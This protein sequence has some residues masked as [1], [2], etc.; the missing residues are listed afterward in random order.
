M[1]MKRCPVCGEKYSDT[2]R[3][4]PFCEEE[5]ALRDGE[6]IR[7]SPRRG[8]RAPHG[9][10]YSLITPTLIVLILI[11]AGLLIY[12]LY[13]DRIAEKFG[14]DG[15]ADTPPTEDVTPPIEPVEPSVGDDGEGQEPDGDNSGV[16]PE[17]P[18]DTTV[19]PSVT[20]DYDKL[21][22]LPGGL[23]LSTTDFTLK[24]VG[25]TATIRVTSGGSGSYTWASEDE[26]VASVD[27]SGK[28]TAV[29]RGT[30][31][32]VVSDGSK[33]GVCIVR[34]NVSGSAPATTPSTTPSTP[35]T[36]TTPSTGSGLKAGAATVVNGGNGVF[37]RS[38]PGTSYEALATVPN[39]ADIQIVESAGDG[40]YK[41]TF[42][43]VGGSTATGYMKGDFLANK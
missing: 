10:Q 6:E 22:A 41:I 24:T 23:G 3:D 21:M 8:K 33:K 20:T 31:N 18:D 36:T 43:D 35:A 5:E 4:C 40:W 14:K 27:Q 19:T 34:C 26:G 32:I 16:M 15:E 37:V 30:V 38:G 42:S 28:V 9:R 39:G 11:M 25:E 2:Y 29:S 13:G 1:A 17:G 12:L 7:R